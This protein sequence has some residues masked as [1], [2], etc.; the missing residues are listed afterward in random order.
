MVKF[1]P[2]PTLQDQETSIDNL[3][4]P[5]SIEAPKAEFG[6]G[7]YKDYSF[8][9]GKAKPGSASGKHRE[10]LLFACSE[11]ERLASSMDSDPNGDKE[12]SGRLLGKAHELRELA[13]K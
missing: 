7:R 6:Y 5:P 10:A 8:C 1:E 11:Y 3:L 13:G 4:S 2:A 12:S 9:R